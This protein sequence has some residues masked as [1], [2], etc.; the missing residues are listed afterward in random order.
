MAEYNDYNSSLTA[1][2][3]ESTLLS[4]VV[5][6]KSMG[7]TE[8][9]KAQARDNIG[10]GSADNRFVVLGYFA[11]LDELVAAVP[12]PKAGPF[13]GVGEA[14]PYDFY[15]WDELHSRWVNNGHLKGM[16]GKDAE[17]GASVEISP[18]E[19]ENPELGDMWYDSD[20]GDPV[21]VLADLLYPVGSIYMSV[22]AANP[23]NIFGGTWQRIKDRFLL[24]AGD[25]YTA[26]ATGGEAEHTLTVDEMPSHNHSITT[27]SNA[28]TGNYYGNPPTSSNAGKEEVNNTIISKTGGSQPH[29]NMPPYLAVYVWQRIA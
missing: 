12:E 2:E 13:Y 23:S 3:I 20:D 1:E 9:Q 7:L 14:E 27:R 16:D 29:N 25:T 4:A 8:A 11:T 6:N 26:G 5:H 21:T 15:S 19:P 22:K 17:D 18:V 28:S 10:A 24:A